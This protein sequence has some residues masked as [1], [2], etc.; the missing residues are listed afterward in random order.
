METPQHETL[1]WLLS[2]IITKRQLLYEERGTYATLD[3]NLVSLHHMERNDYQRA[4]MIGSWN[5]PY[6]TSLG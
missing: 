5:I 1:Y 4:I 3:S 6:M 2:S